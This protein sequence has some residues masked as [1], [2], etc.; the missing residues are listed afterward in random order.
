MFPSKD[1]LPP[2]DQYYWDLKLKDGRVFPIPPKAVELIKRK[3]AE[4]KPII[5]TEFT[6]P[7]SEVKGFDKTSRKLRDESTKLLEESAQAFGFPIITEEGAVKARY[8]KKEVTSHEWSTYYSKGSYKNLLSENGMVWI[9][10]TLPVH[11]IDPS[12]HSYLTP[13]EEKRLTR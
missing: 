10:F 3:I 5:T 6:V 9:A 8:V 2:Q 7:F 1:V 12:R 11:Q 4:K 13:D